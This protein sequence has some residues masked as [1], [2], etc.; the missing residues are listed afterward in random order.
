MI[1]AVSI[2]SGGL[3]ST[4]S[5]ALAIRSGVRVSQAVFFDYGQKAARREREASRTIARHYGAAWREIA[6]PW[7]GAVTRTSLVGR[8]A[9]PRVSEKDLDGTR[10]RETAKAVWVPN[11]NGVFLN[12]AAAVAESIGAGLIVTGFDREEAATFP[13]NSRAFIAA[14]SRALRYSTANHV[15]V[16]SFVASMDKAAIVRAGLRLKVPLGKTWSCYLGGKRPCGR[17]ESCMRSI[18]ALRRGGA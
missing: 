6:L 4:V 10:A 13:D 1:R 7:L 3:D 5:T 12:A 8:S 11:R 9:P 15:R 17:C 18:R 2:L 16:R 14:A